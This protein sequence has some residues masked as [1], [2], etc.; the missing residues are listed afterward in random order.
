MLASVS[1]LG[2]IVLGGLGMAVIALVGAGVLLFGELSPRMNLLLVALSAGSLLGGALFHMLPGALSTAST[3][4]TIFVWVAAG[5]TIFLILEQFLQ[6]HHCHR[7]CEGHDR[8]PLGILILIADGVH[9]LLGGLAVGGAFVV[10]PRLG[11][12]AWVAAAA[13]EIPQEL[14]DFGVLMH[15]G[16]SR[17]R[18]LAFNFLSALTFLVG[19]LLAWALARRVD[20]TFLVPLAAGNFLYI[21]AADLIPEI[22][23]EP[24]F[25]RGLSHFAAFITG[26]LMMLCLALVM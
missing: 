10:D 24:S 13:H 16:W 8:R 20:P 19:G 1:V 14:G 15:A 17:S 11:I 4:L 23:H 3:P 7:G 26:L 21:A 9:N 22:K 12:A 5:F 2:W 18:A 6:W 25:R